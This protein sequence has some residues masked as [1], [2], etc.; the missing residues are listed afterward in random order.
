[1]AAAVA[2]AASYKLNRGFCS[3]ANSV[4]KVNGKCRKALE[5]VVE[6]FR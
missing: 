6:K 2:T 5:R 3:S 4:G 1:M